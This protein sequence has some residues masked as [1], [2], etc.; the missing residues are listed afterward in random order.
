MEKFNIKEQID[1]FND[2]YDGDA[3]K[4]PL[5]PEIFH[6]TTEKEQFLII[7][8]SLNSSKSKN[9]SENLVGFLL[10]NLDSKPVTSIRDS[11]RALY[12]S[13]II[14]YLLSNSKISVE[15]YLAHHAILKNYNNIVL[16]NNPEVFLDDSVK[17]LNTLEEE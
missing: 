7:D 17:L 16:I 9:F 10:D 14:K 1:L 4:I 13:Q 12:R 11:W 3:E 15:F 6:L 8:R 5:V 2:V